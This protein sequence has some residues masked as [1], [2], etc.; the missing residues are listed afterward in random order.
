MD[1]H[2]VP[3]MYFFIV[4]I[5]FSYLLDKSIDSMKRG[6]WSASIL[7]MS[8]GMQTCGAASQQ[9]LDSQSGRPDVGRQKCP[10]HCRPGPERCQNGMQRPLSFPHYPKITTMYAFKNPYHALHTLPRMLPGQTCRAFLFT[11]TILQHMCRVSVAL[12]AMVHTAHV[13]RTLPTWNTADSSLRFMMSAQYLSS[14][15]VIPTILASCTAY[16]DGMQRP[17]LS[18]LICTER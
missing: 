9:V 15:T 12:N 18:L 16:Q 3:C 10:G 1:I 13:P 17:S 5:Y 8:L 11:L 6:G 2:P 14:S 4:I 7:K